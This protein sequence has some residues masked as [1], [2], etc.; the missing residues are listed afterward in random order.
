MTKA[1]PKFPRPHPPT[2]QENLSSLI[3]AYAEQEG[4]ADSRVRRAVAY[5]F[6]ACAMSKKMTDGSASTFAIQGGAAIE[7][8]FKLRS[9]ATRDI[10]ALVTALESHDELS[11]AVHSALAEATFGDVIT[12]R[13]VGEDRRNRF[14]RFQV[15]TLWNGEP[16]A[17][18]QVEASLAPPELE[19]ADLDDLEPLRL[20]EQFGIKLDMP[21]I[22]ALGVPI[23]LANK[24]HSV[25]EPKV[26]NDRARDLIDIVFL[27]D[28][29]EKDV[30]T[31]S[32][33]LRAF[34]SRGTHPW[35]PTATVMNGW[36]ATFDDE[37]S[38]VPDFPYSDVQ[39]CVVAVNQIIQRIHRAVNEA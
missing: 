9:R 39:S 23:Q 37:V 17:R 10:D 28:S 16:F 31:R 11:T 2:T 6:I 32:K 3:S 12:F 13:I 15:Q 8:R 25:T 14:I 29:N 1:P 21:K 5:E 26:D 27:G 22:V 4:I 30:T 38:G 34:D 18:S 36:E 24:F 19:D 20:A 33:C 35:P 7:I